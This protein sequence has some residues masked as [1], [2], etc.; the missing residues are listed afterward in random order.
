MLLLFDFNYGMILYM[1]INSCLF[2]RARD[3]KIIFQ[4]LWQLVSYSLCF[5]KFYDNR[6]NTGQLYSEYITKKNKNL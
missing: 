5:N 6:L 3:T 1:G 4:L 2:L